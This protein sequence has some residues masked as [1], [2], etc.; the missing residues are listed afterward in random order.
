MIPDLPKEGLV[1]VD[2]AE[3]DKRVSL[4]TRSDCGH[5]TFDGDILLSLCVAGNNW[6]LSPRWRGKR[7]R[8]EKN[9]NK[10]SKKRF[11][12]IRRQ[13]VLRTL[14]IVGGREKGRSLPE[15]AHFKALRAE[16]PQNC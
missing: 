4:P 9:G 16:V 2:S 6:R 10:Q 7:C 1:R 8:H 13:C 14:P 15:A 12:E 11:H 5:N 3:V